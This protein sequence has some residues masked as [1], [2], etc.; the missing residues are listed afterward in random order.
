MPAIRDLLPIIKALELTT[1]DYPDLT[2]RMKYRIA[3]IQPCRRSTPVAKGLGRIGSGVK[4]FLAV[5]HLE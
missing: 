3:L 1:H 2:A 5:Y 4:L